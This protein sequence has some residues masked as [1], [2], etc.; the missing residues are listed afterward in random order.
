MTRVPLAV[1]VACCCFA[2]QPATFKIAGHVVRHPGERPIRGAKV[3]ITMVQD[4]QRQLSAVNGENGE[5]LFYGLPQAKYQLRVEYRGAGQFFHELEGYSTAIAVGPNI[6]SEHI[7]FPFDTGASINGTLVDEVGD[8]VPGAT[9]YLFAKTVSR[10]FYQTAAAGQSNTTSSGTFHFGHLAPGTYYVAAAGRPWYA[11]NPIGDQPQIAVSPELYVAFPL[12]YYADGTT[13][14]AA[15][16][17]TLEEGAKTEIQMTLR[18][19]PAVHISLD[20]FEENQ[21]VQTSLFQTGPGGTHINVVGTFGINGMAAVAP[22][23]YEISANALSQNQWSEIGSQAIKAEGDSTFHLGD[24]IKT[25]VT[26]KVALAGALP[27]ALNVWLGNT[28]N[29]NIIWL[30]IAKDGSFNSSQVSPGHYSLLMGNTNE[31]YIQKLKVEGAPFSNGVLEVANGAQINLDI[32]AAKGMTNIDGIAMDGK[33]PVA[34]A[35]ILAIP[36]DQ[37]RAK[38]IPRDQ[39]DSDGTFTLAELPPG[40]YTIVAVQD[41][42]NLAYAEPGVITPYLA[43]GQVVDVPLAKDSKLEIQVQP[44]R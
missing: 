37:I 28:A 18:A 17:L 26:G 16:P 4:R 44:R 31:F 43:G 11:R 15:T 42:R 25:S 39:S 12:T 10:G 40:R 20:G 14:E 2:Q 41:G 35:I 3:S 30:P 6:D 38:Y 34:G 7:V 22:G 33:S 9:V 23:N 32:T 36:Q 24:S 29:G 21:Q 5:F 1:L 27:S 19:V 8:P 13:P